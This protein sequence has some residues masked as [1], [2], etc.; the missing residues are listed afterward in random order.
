MD[1]NDLLRLGYMPGKTLGIALKAAKALVVSGATE[2]D[3]L[4]RVANVLNSPDDYIEDPAFGPVAEAL[5]GQRTPIHPSGFDLEGSAPYLIWG[6]NSIEPG[7]VEQM[8]RAVRLPVAVKGA[9]MPD[10]HQG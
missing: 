3:A 10:A 7:A 6:G 4:S 9:L 8:K 2:A 1:G 5:I